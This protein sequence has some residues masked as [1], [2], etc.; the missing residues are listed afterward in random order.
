M[1]TRTQNNTGRT[2]AV[3]SGGALLA[4]LLWRGR[5]KGKGKGKGN[6]GDA[7]NHRSASVSVRIR[8]GDQID[9]DG[10]SSDLTTTVA[11]AHAAGAARVSATG[12]ARHGWVTQVIAALKAEN[13]AIDAAPS[14]F[15]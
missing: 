1:T 10:V 7:G 9:L 3:I 2:I 4:W 14:L 11:R 5:G 8:A 6:E 12:D 13:V 15:T